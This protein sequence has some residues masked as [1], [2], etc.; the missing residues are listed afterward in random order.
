MNEGQ[1][2]L[3]VRLG[4]VASALIEGEDGNRQDA[5]DRAILELQQAARRSHNAA[6]AAGAG[7]DLVEAIE[8]LA[9]QITDQ[10]D[11][12]SAVRFQVMKEMQMIRLLIASLMSKSD[13]GQQQLL[14]FATEAVEKMR[15]DA[16]LLLER[17]QAQLAAQDTAFQTA[18]RRDMQLGGDGQ[19]MDKEP[20]IER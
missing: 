19:D 14:S 4:P 5:L 18:I 17:E 2:T 20:E 15:T 1:Q 11:I 7:T 9:G 13:E 8:E 12:L 10:R 6:A 3:R 16:G